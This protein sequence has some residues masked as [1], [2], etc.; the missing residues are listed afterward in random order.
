M[1]KTEAQIL[2][3]VMDQTHKLGR[4]YIGTLK[5]V[6]VLKEF[7]AEGKKL[8]CVLWTLAH[9]TW[10]EDALLLKTLNGPAT[11]ITWLSQFRTATDS[12]LQTGWPP[13]NEVLEG[14]KHVHDVSLKFVSS[15]D[16]S[17][18]DEPVYIKVIDWNTDKRHA[19]MHAIRHEG[20]HVGHL[21]WLCKLHG[22][23]T[24]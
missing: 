5:E 11:N 13:L 1:E 10:A 9:M 15:L 18:L 19:I 12:S 14:M 2:A 20:V 16:D 23:K 3:E 7:E 22:I 17:V 4:F 6:D 21:S 24:I 8:N